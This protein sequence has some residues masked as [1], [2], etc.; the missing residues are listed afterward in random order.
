MLTQPLRPCSSSTVAMQSQTVHCEVYFSSYAMPACCCQCSSCAISVMSCMLQAACCAL[1]TMHSILH[2]ST[3]RTASM[4]SGAWL[5]CIVDTL[6][7]AKW[8]YMS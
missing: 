6:C 1:D 5:I 2:T 8:H 3:P 7:C 4:Q